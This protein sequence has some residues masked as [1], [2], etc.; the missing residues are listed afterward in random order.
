MVAKQ[1]RAA[2]T[3]VLDPGDLVGGRQ[4]LAATSGTKAEVLSD[5][6]TTRRG[7]VNHHSGFPMRH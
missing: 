7:L 3:S 2:R 6:S 1:E 5:V 4:F